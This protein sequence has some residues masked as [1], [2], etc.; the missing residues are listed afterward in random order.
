[1]ENERS[2]VAK[3]ESGIFTA[4]KPLPIHAKKFTSKAY[5]V[6]D[7]IYEGETMIRHWFRCT[8]CSKVFSA[9]TSNGTGPLMSHVKNK[10][11]KCIQP[12]KSHKDNNVHYEHTENDLSGPDT[13]APNMKNDKIRI[14][15]NDLALV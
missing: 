5:S 13:N 14:S 2:V 8:R 15:A 4:R 1:M 3:L 10:R 7:L 11:N 12:A 9:D 6:I